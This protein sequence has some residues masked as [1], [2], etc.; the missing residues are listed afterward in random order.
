MADDVHQTANHGGELAQLIIAYSSG[1][2]T[3]EEV[4]E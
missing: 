1:A 3:Y 4:K 2:R